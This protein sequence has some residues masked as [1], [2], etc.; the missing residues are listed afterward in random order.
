MRNMLNALRVGVALA[1]AMPAVAAPP[2]EI[3]GLVRVK[4]SRFQAAYVLPGADFRPYTKVMLDPTVASM[5]KNYRQSIN[6]DTVG[7]N[8]MV[9]KDDVQRIVQTAQTQFDG[10]LRTAFVKAGYQLASAPGPDVVLLK[11]YIIDLYVNAPD[12]QAPGMVRSYVA[13]AGSATLVYEVRDSQT[14]AMLAQVADAQD[15][16]NMPMR[17]NSVTNLAEFD[18]LFARW[19]DNTARGLTLLKQASPIPAKLK[20]NQ[21]LD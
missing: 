21:K 1:L 15:T 17:A 20:P 7:L 11:P 6:M 13:E 8:M 16:S 9:T 14:N 3:D 2:G 4:A 10:A 18:Q 19:A 12:T 5:A